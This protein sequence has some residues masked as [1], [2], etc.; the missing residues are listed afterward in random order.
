[1]PCEPGRPPI[2]ARAAASG[3]SRSAEAATAKAASARLPATGHPLPGGLRARMESSFGRSF[4]AT[5]L[6]TDGAGAAFARSAGAEAVTI[7]ED[8][9]F[10]PGRYR[11]GTQSGDELI[12]HELAHVT[13]QGAGGVPAAPQA[14]SEAPLPVAHPAEQEAE[15]AAQRAVA[16][17]SAGIAPGGRAAATR[18]HLLRRAALGPADAAPMLPPAGT[19][20][21]EAAPGVAD[22]EAAG[23][24]R[25]RVEEARREGIAEPPVPVPARALPRRG[26]PAARAPAAPPPGGALPRRAAAPRT[27]S[28]AVVT[29]A[30]PAPVAAPAPRVAP[31]A[32][33][34]PIRAPP[35]AAAAI[36]ATPAAAPDAAARQ[37]EAVSEGP[38]SEESAAAE[39]EAAEAA[40]QAPEAAQAEGEAQPA[41]AE[42]VSAPDAAAGEAV[43]AAAEGEQAA[44]PDA[45]APERSPALSATLARI[46]RT[47]WVQGHN[48]PAARKAAEAQAAA[49]GPENERTA[50]AAAGQVATMD[51]QEPG[52]FDREAFKAAVRAKI[53]EI[54]PATLKEMEAFKSSGGMDRVK[55]AVAGEVEGGKE[56]AAGPVQQAAEAT[57]DPSGQP[58]K[59]QAP[60]PPTEAGPAP[61]A[62]GAEQAVPP[63]APEAAVDVSAGPQ[64]IEQRMTEANVSEETL[65]RSNEPEFTAAVDAKTEAAADAATAPATYR[66]EEEALRGGVAQ[67]QGAAAEAGVAAMHGSRGAEFAA[68]VSAQ[69]AT[70]DA[71]RTTRDQVF[72][73]L[74]GIHAETQSQVTARLDRMES[75]ATTRFSTG[76]EAASEAA[77]TYVDNAIFN[78]KLERYLSIPGLGAAAWVRDQFLGLPE[79]VNAFYDQAM[80][81]FY[82]TMDALLDEVGGIVETGLNEAKAMIAEGRARVDAY[83]AGLDPSLAQVGQEATA[84]IQ[85]RFDALASSVDERRDRLVN[86]I[87]QSFVQAANSLHERLDAIRAANRGLVDR[88]RDLIEGVL[89]T[90]AE[91]K[92]ML[93]GVAASAAAVIDQI[94]AD[95][96]GFLGNLIA[97]IR[98]GLGAFLGNI[99]THLR[100]GFTG[101]LFG[102]M[103]A[104]GIQMPE[105]FDLRGI[106]SLVLQIFGVT[107]ANF[108]ARAVN[109]VGEPLV[110]AMEGAVEIFRVLV[111]EGPG[112]LW[113]F[114]VEQLGNLKD[115]LMEEIQSWLITNVITAGITW[116]LSMFNPASAF[117]RAVKMII[118]VVM[119][120][121][122]RGSQVMALVQ[123]VIGSLAA[124][125]SGSIGA[126]ASA[127]EG[128]LARAVPVAIGFLASLLGLGGIASTIQG[129]IQ[130]LQAPVNRAIDW[131]VGKAVA[132]GRRIGGLFSRN[133][134]RD[135]RRSPAE[136]PEREAQIQRGLAQIDTEEGRYLDAGKITR[137]EAEEVARKVKRDN[138]V[139]Q[140]ITVMD[141]GDSW[142]YA[143][144]ASD[145]TKEGPPQEE[146]ARFTDQQIVQ[147]KLRAVELARGD[148]AIRDAYE[149]QR[150]GFMSALTSP[151]GDIVVTSGMSA[152]ALGHAA[153]DVIARPGANQG[154]IPRFGT[155]RAVVTVAGDDQLLRMRTTSPTQ[156]NIEMAGNPGPTGKGPNFGQTYNQIQRG[157]ELGAADLGLSTEQMQ[158]ALSYFMRHA[159]LPEDLRNHPQSG[160][161]RRRLGEL[162]LTRAVSEQV[163]SPSTIASTGIGLEQI[164]TTSAAT[165]AAP[166][167]SAQMAPIG[168]ASPEAGRGMAAAIRTSEDQARGREPRDAR[169]GE[170]TA[171]RT[172]YDTNLQRHADVSRA[173]IDSILQGP[174]GA[175][176]TS[177]EA[178]AQRIAG[179]IR[180]HM[181]ED[182]RRG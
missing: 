47:A 126:L 10:A 20:D 27:A 174:D 166:V 122:Q 33:G 80:A 123:A 124:I 58:A 73:A 35:E 130:K 45:E 13:Q 96:I 175:R 182:A 12:A 42:A 39:Q 26:E 5:R 119:F 151:S 172:T 81:Q 162:L 152:I 68:I 89:K 157:L 98:Q 32:R 146:G 148:P 177:V 15:A 19:A 88:A 121:I 86:A 94:I 125:A 90:I 24:Q 147:A 129:F 87:A 167:S 142:D 55:G 108:R 145:G 95:P 116:L 29:P 127:V 137:R 110:A 59:E 139:F 176:M 6:H 136:N 38:D 168:S 28:A 91:L 165:P 117:V 65:A 63:P 66:A 43:P 170:G 115:M 41:K 61:A 102:T 173:Q 60:L 71:D 82:A 17:Q 134:R 72:A 57:P 2:R 149:T 46:R 74:E 11:P 150:E 169:P 49:P 44:A 23:I 78:Y 144:R 114:L 140:S 99:G 7:G 143:Y 156:P 135:D 83:V 56:A 178:L 21:I 62:L 14:R 69:G 180:Q 131:L 154:S 48:N 138:P 132:L 1:M 141:G 133:G 113:R 3:P 8:I 105:S 92:Q 54:A 109:I 120:F 9:A 103:A 31:Q 111:T 36:L 37:A 4:S 84:A 75:D 53:A 97:G 181:L 52:T 171:G 50:R 106:I 118:D 101:W 67:Q 22:A 34:P 159:D 64:S 164:R 79:E 93:L 25:R 51:G 160:R 76:A 107:Y 100:N 70:Q 85:Q 163:R 179:L 112:G 16:G 40:T 18:F 155:G 158:R 104:A 77:V 30:G 128:A 161:L 153:S